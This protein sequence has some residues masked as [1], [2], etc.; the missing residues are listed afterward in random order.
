MFKIIKRVLVIYKKNILFDRLVSKLKDWGSEIVIATSME[1]GLQDYIHNYFCLTILDADISE[2]ETSIVIKQMRNIRPNPIMVLS[3]SFKVTY[4]IELLQA[5]ATA[6]L[7][8]SCDVIECFAYVKFL[9]QLFRDMHPRFD[10]K[11]ILAFGTELV[12]DC[13]KHQVYLNGDI[14]SLTR[15]EFELLYYLA[16]YAGQVLSREQLYEI[17]WGNSNSYNVD[18]LIKAHIKSIRKKMSLYNENYIQNERGMG[19][20]FFIELKQIEVCSISLK[21]PDFLPD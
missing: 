1:S 4:K 9:V 11:N 19:Y 8:N 15:K 7:N 12:I 10:G 2:T 21:N 5:G 6:I 14:I 20:R 16:S 3:T 13:G 17:V 18:E